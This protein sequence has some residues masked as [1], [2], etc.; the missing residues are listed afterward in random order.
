[1]G[2]IALPA[3]YVPSAFLHMQGKIVVIPHLMQFPYLYIQ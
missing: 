2:L 1:M 3:I